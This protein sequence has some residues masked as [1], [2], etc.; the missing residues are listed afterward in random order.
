[1]EIVRTCPLGH[2]CEEAKDN[3]IYRCMWFK[4]LE[5]KHPVTNEP[6]K[7]W[8]CAISWQPLLQTEIAGAITKT[9]AS[10]DKVSTK[11]SEMSTSPQLRI[12]KRNDSGGS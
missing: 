10:T 11:I 5:G 4:E 3:K 12:I 7:E 9:T 2:I 6:I 8:D 1:M